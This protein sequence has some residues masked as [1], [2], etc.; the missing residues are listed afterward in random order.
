MCD[1]IFPD[2]WQSVWVKC[3]W[4]CDCVITVNFRLR[5]TCVGAQTKA[6][7]SVARL[8]SVGHSAI[9]S[10]IFISS[11]HVQNHK[12]DDE[13]TSWVKHAP[14]QLR[15]GQRSSQL[16]LQA[17]P[18]LRWRQTVSWRP[19]RCRFRPLRT[20]VRWPNP[21]ASERDLQPGLW[22]APPGRAT[23]WTRDPAFV[24]GSE[25]RWR[26]PERGVHVF[27]ASSARWSKLA[28]CLVHCHPLKKNDIEALGLNM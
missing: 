18:P 24:P 27:R 7:C 8:D 22:P 25:C 4:L 14:V 17:G 3:K 15:T 2:L 11:H 5:L 10:F 21:S 28:H 6:T 13:A 12:P 26:D 20:S 1:M 23:A 16:T 9:F 19:G